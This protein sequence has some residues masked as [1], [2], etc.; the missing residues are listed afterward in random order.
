MAQD[1]G[2]SLLLTEIC[3]PIPREQTFDANDDILSIG[4]NHPQ[5]CFWSRREIFVDEF[6]TLLI[7]NA[8]L[9]R[10]RV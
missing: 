10:V 6:R 1:K 2:D 5:K 4:R 3:Y 8:D 7:E 9:H